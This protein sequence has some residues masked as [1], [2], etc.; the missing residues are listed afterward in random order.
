VTSFTVTGHRGQDVVSITW[1]DGVLSGDESACRMVRAIAEHSEGTYV[2]CPPAAGVSHDHLQNAWSTFA[3][4]HS[5]FSDTPRVT[6]GE[7]P[8]VV[9]DIPNTV[10]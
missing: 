5:V 9:L 8:E 10:I 3:L 6:A 7:L 2:P 4:M 1:T